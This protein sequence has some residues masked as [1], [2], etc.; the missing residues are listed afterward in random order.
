MRSLYSSQAGKALL[1][2][3][4]RKLVREKIDAFAGSPDFSH[5]NVLKLQ[6]REEYRLRV[7]NWRILFRIEDGAMIID[8]I[9]PRGSV[10]E[11]KK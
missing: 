3:N 2:C 1:K 10:Y 5:P 9:A 4:K 6:G 11:V 8:N 7:Q